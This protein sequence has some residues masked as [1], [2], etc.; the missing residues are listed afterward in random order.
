MNYWNKK[1]MYN[2][3]NNNNNNN[4]FMNNIIIKIIIFTHN[5]VLIQSYHIIIINNNNNN[6]HK[7]NKMHSD[8]YSDIFSSFHCLEQSSP[9][10]SYLHVGQCSFGQHVAVNN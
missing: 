2:N 3:N 4:R 9:V 1:K 6:S 5:T 8:T 10:R 7:Y